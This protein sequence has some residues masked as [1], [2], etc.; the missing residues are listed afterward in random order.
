MFTRRKDKREPTQIISSASRMAGILVGT[1]VGIGKKAP[2][3]RVFVKAK[4]LESELDTTTH[5]LVVLKEK[6]EKTQSQLSF[7]V[8]A[9]QEKKESL[10]SV[11]RQSR[12][13]TRS[14]K[15][16]ESKMSGR[17][18]ALETELAAV[19]NKL[20]KLQ[21]KTKIAQSQLSSQLDSLQAKNRSLKSTL[22]QTQN[23][24]RGIKAKQTRT[25]GRAAALKTEL[26][27]ANDTLA[28]LQEKTKK[29]Q[30]Q[31]SL[32]IDSLQEKNKSLNFLLRQARNE[33]KSAKI[34]ESNMSRRAATLQT[35]LTTANSRLAETKRKVEKTPA[36]L[37]AQL[38]ILQKKNKSALMVKE[39]KAVKTE[40]DQ[41][42]QQ[43]YDSCS[44]TQPGAIKA[45]KQQ[46]KK[47]AKT[48]R[49]GAK[50]KSKK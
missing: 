36:P 40:V 4:A 24:V 38:K 31:L 21:E 35:K 10:N 7:K 44:K 25:S 5:E 20:T 46:N 27:A 16:K 17:A 12:N 3:I 14:A 43:I 18:A 48:S 30:S 23:K 15:N 50:A 29:V 39:I 33:V 9:L 26:A 22:K 47:Q 42:I 41:L 13:N 49:R 6:A 19:N 34:N 32:Q 28:K 8:D 1:T 11:L 45:T 37:S 2:G